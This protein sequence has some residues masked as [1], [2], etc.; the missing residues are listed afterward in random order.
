MDA[1]TEMIDVYEVVS[2]SQLLT[3]FELPNITNESRTVYWGL[4]GVQ[5][6]R[7]G[8]AVPRPLQLEPPRPHGRMRTQP[9]PL[10]HLPR[11][12]PLQRHRQRGKRVLFYF[13]FINVSHAQVLI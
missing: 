9:Q 8:Q 6:R 10:P 5:R 2:Y 12:P 4:I 13:L 3:Y 7:V 11:R 1:L